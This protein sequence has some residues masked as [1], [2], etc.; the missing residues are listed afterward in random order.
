MK[1]IGQYDGAL[2]MFKDL[3]GEVNMARS[4]FLR[5]L[6]ERGLL[7]HEVAGPSAG[8]FAVTAESA[9]ERTADDSE[10]HMLPKAS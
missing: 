1:A 9:P 7:E 2:Q 8:A 3:P 4:R 5:W 6:G 10:L